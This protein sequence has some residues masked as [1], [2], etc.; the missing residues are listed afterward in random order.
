[1]DQLWTQQDGLIDILKLDVEGAELE[2][3]KGARNLLAGRRV[4]FIF[5]E[6]LL[7]PYYEERVTLGHQQ[8]FLDE[9]GYRLIALNSDHDGYSWRPT[10]IRGDADR[11]MAYAGDAIFVVDPDRTGLDRDTSYR[12][13]LACLAMGFHSFGLNLI[14]E[15]GLVPVTDI[16][17]IEAAA[18]HVSFSRKL[19]QAWMDAPDHAYRLLRLLGLRP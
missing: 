14:R 13:G 18:N 19:R 9:L 15:T 12:L 6:F 1:M 5:T 7:V 2:V 8:V 3:L 17:A 16:Q 11:R 10:G 4:L